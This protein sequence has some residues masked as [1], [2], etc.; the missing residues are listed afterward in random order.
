M[1]C[2][3]TTWDWISSVPL[4]NSAGTTVYGW[5]DGVKNRCS[6]TNYALT[7]VETAVKVAA[8]V[9]Q[10]VVKKVEGKC[11]FSY[12]MDVFGIYV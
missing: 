3:T 10:P 4:A 2:P 12:V 5:Y 8:G 7:K 1:S 11:T 9:T 6:L